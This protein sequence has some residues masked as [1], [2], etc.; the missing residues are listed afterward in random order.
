MGNIRTTPNFMELWTGEQARQVREKVRTCPKNCWMVG[1]AAPVMKK[2]IKHPAKWVIKN[3]LR[4][5]IGK[6]AVLDKCWHNVGQDPRQGD[7]REV[8]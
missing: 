1:T 4:S 3:K 8:L 5:V 2:Y 6:D 7:L